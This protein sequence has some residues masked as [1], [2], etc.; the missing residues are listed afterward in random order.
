MRG[1]VEEEMEST[2]WLF[3]STDGRTRESEV[4]P[5]AGLPETK[6]LLFPG[7]HLLGADPRPSVNSCATK[8]VFNVARPRGRGMGTRF[9]TPKDH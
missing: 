5:Q 4:R 8:N 3:F 2:R 9:S 1:L 7:K 6:L